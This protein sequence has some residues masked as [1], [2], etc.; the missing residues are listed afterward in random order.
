MVS[1]IEQAA[2]AVEHARPGG[3]PLMV[4]DLSAR[5]GGELAG[6]RSHRT[7]RDADLLF[8]V[9][10]PEGVPIQSPGFVRFG[11]DGLALIPDRLGGPYFVRLDVAREWLLVKALVTSPD[12]NVQ[13][14][15]V[16]NEVEGLILQYARALDEAPEVLWHAETVMHQPG[17]SL[18][19]DDHLHLRTAC[20]P[21]EAL[22]GCEGG[23]PYWPWLPE[24]PHAEPTDDEALLAALLN[25]FAQPEPPLVRLPQ[26]G[27][28]AGLPPAS[29]HAAPSVSTG[30]GS[31]SGD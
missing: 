3:F 29:E 16:S 25:P 18:P 13:W 17:D 2:S 8:Y 26:T 27:D 23:G 4:G 9:Q 6:H 7:G 22:A 19:H 5:T 20:L 24:L 30:S 15:F 1:A 28:N 21:D 11:A 10:T 31:G 12:A 14:L